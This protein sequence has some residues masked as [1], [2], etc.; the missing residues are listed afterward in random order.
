MYVATSASLYCSPACGAKYR[1]S[2]AC[3][4]VPV[5]PDAISWDYCEPSGIAPAEDAP[6]W[7]ADLA[8]E[9]R[10][11]PIWSG[12]MADVQLLRSK[13]IRPI[14]RQER[15]GRAEPAKVAPMPT[16]TPKSALTAVL[17][18]STGILECGRC[19]QNF[20][21]PNG[22]EWHVANRPNCHAEKAR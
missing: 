5:P 22:R 21:T 20:R 3:E 13:K 2:G 16:R 9:D 10:A 19:H 15:P 11:A 18:R 17:A 14:S 4:P 12:L 7:A 8:S 1:Q 6:G